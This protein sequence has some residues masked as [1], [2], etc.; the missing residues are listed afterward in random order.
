M[1]DYKQLFQKVFPKI[2]YNISE[3]DVIEYEVIYQ[4][5]IETNKL[6]LVVVEYKRIL[7]PNKI[8]ITNKVLNQTLFLD[9]QTISKY[10]NAEDKSFIIKNVTDSLIYL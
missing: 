2:S 4:D 1:R 9:L 3:S 7:P 5:I 6:L 8:K 10:I